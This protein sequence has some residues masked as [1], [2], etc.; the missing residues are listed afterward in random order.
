[1]ALLG[2]WK[3]LGVPGCTQSANPPMDRETWTSWEIVL[4]AMGPDRATPE[5]AGLGL[6]ALGLIGINQKQVRVIN[7][8][9]GIQ[10]PPGHLGLI[11]AR[12]SLALQ[13]VHVM[14]GGIDA[15]YQGEIKVML[16]NDNEQ[17]WII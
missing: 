2:K 14:G 15:D 11:T 6:R 12:W 8:G 10:I 4:G 13:N 17:D 5:A 9:I 3:P 16:L 7:A 1:M